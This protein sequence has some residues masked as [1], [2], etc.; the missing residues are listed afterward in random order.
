MLNKLYDKIDL[1]KS[2]KNLE[3][4]KMGK[5]EKRK[6]NL[7]DSLH[8]DFINDILTNIDIIFFELIKS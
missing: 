3:R 4:R 8:W 1:L 6:K 2:L 7:V 5:L